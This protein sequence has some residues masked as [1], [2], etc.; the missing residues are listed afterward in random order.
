MPGVEEMGPWLFLVLA[1]VNGC[2][3]S[4]LATSKVGMPDQP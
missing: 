2:M 1:I 4:S 3:A